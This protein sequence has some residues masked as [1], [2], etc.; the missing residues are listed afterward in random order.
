M[1]F[2]FICLFILLSTIIFSIS[3][4]RIKVINLKY[5]ISNTRHIN[6]NFK[7]KIQLIIF[8]KIKIINIDINKELL[9]KLKFREKL[10]KAKLK[11]SEREIK[12]NKKVLKYIPKINLKTNYLNLNIELGT[13]N[14]A[15]TSLIIPIVSGIISIILSKNSYN[16][17]NIYYNVEPIYYNQNIFNI[18]LS[19]I[20]EIKMI[21]IINII[22]ILN[23]NKG[24]IKNERASYRR[25]YG[26]SYE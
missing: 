10:E 8:N 2:L 16:E 9:E 4:I 26:Y 3:K 14:S 5:Y 17:K 23:K 12:I 13:E 22:Y 21:H 18:E 15:L 11:F 1:V 6:D 7:F 19:G 24:V 25:A 20:F